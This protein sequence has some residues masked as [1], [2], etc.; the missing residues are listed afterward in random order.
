MASARKPTSAER[1]SLSD[2]RILRAE[3]QATGTHPAAIAG[4]RET[5]IDPDLRLTPADRLRNGA[6]AEAKKELAL[7]SAKENAPGGAPNESQAREYAGLVPSSVRLD[8]TIRD[9]EDLVAEIA[10]GTPVFVEIGIDP[11][12]GKPATTALLQTGRNWRLHYGI[13]EA[14]GQLVDNSAKDTWPVTDVSRERKCH[15]LRHTK[16]IIEA[17]KASATER[18]KEIDAVVELAQNLIRRERGLL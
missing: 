6:I 18:A 14:T 12:E 17:A 9:L 1:L 16:F 15:I 7:A 11:K 2:Q 13:Q 3:E 5:A 8:E 10:Q 4:K